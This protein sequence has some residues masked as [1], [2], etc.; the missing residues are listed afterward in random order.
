[1]K[2][3]FPRISN[4]FYI[5]SPP[6]T[7][8][9]AG[10]SALHLLCHYLNKAGFQAFIVQ[11]PL[12]QRAA[13][14]L[15]SIVSLQDVGDYPLGLNAPIITQDV[16]EYFDELKLTPIVIYPEVYDN[17]FEVPF[18]GRYILNYPGLLAP[19]FTEKEA[20]N[21]AYSKILA[22]S[23]PERT[24]G[25]SAPQDVLFMPTCDLDY[26]SPPT[27][28]PSIRTGAAYY[29]GK[30]KAIHGVTP[31]D[32]PRDAIEILR[33]TQM[34]TE[35]VREIFQSSEAFYCYEDTAL[36]IEA[37]LCGCPTI[38]VPHAHF[39]GR[40]L[41]EFETG[42]EGSARLGEAEGERYAMETVGQFRD[43]MQSSMAQ[44][45]VRIAA[46]AQKWTDLARAREYGGTIK[47]G[48]VPQV[49]IFRNLIAHKVGYED[50]IV[51]SNTEPEITDCDGR[52]EDWAMGIHY[53][54]RLG[55][56]RFPR[57][58]IRKVRRAIRRA[59]YDHRD[60]GLFEEHRPGK[61]RFP[62]DF[63]RSIRRLKRRLLGTHYT[64]WSG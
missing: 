43:K 53:E 47:L 38:F 56:E 1:M 59:R 33:A 37:R 52:P 40:P 19:V 45:P 61:R 54:R 64:P 16:I 31:S 14:G 60:Y 35:R 2:T 17:P 24:F 48:Y 32:H 63:V 18:F 36:A 30:L 22:E 51:D 10:V 27:K 44:A 21:V 8:I 25:R 20:F 55:K 9:S 26:W 46:L 58:L 23:L 41:A 11:Y 39:D 34:P 7:R 49:A 12:H 13:R 62:R 15:P 6:F 4:P 3:L 28:S 5:V 50:A 42:A 29:A 57:D